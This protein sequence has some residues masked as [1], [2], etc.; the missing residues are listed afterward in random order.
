QKNAMDE[1]IK[2][3]QQACS[4]AK[5]DYQPTG[6]GAGITAFNGGTAD[7]AGSDSALKDGDESTKAAARCGGSPAL[8]LPM[9]TGPIA[10][11]YNLEG[12]KDLQLKPE[13]LAKIFSGAI[14]TWNDAAIKAD[15][16]SAT[17]PSTPILAVHRADSSGTTDNFTGYLTK[18]AASAWTF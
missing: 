11:A 15:N 6:S 9:V 13:T 17:L 18:S 12:V 16:P 4:G 2:A 8:N 7:F 1:W 10:I 5:I 3:Y 14:K